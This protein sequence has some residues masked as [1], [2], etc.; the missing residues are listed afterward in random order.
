MSV[1][2][3]SP[4][5]AAHPDIVAALRS[6][7]ATTGSDFDYL[8]GTAMRESGLNAQ[9]QSKGSTA[10]GLFQ[11]IDQT[12]LGLVKRYGDKF[13]LSNYT[14]AIKDTGNGHYTVDSQQTKQAILALRKDAKVSALMAGQSA[15]DTKQ[16]LEGALGRE[17]DGGEL[18]AAHFLGEGSAKR[19]LALK[20]TQ[21]NCVAASQFP[22]AAPQTD[23]IQQPVVAFSAQSTAAA[24]NILSSFA[25]RVFPAHSDS[26]P[27]AKPSTLPQ[28]PLLLSP[29]VVEILAA[30]APMDLALSK[31]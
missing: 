10:T 2:P 5:T 20:D 14:S 27:P 23:K 7:S 13:G 31:R 22:Q 25:S 30:L 12:W 8:L 15:Q 3:S 4:V 21:P 24:D 29:G 26:A 6:A 16:S 11:F 17:I 28:R 1:Q 9:A 18:Y 19:L